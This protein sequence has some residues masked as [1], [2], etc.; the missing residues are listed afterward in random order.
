MIR[1]VFCFYDF[2]LIFAYLFADIVPMIVEFSYLRSTKIVTIGY[3]CYIF[4]KCLINIAFEWISVFIFDDY[5]FL[6]IWICVG[7]DSISCPPDSNS[8]YSYA[9]SCSL[10]CCNQWINSHI[11]STICDEYDRAL[12]CHAREC[13]VGDEECIPYGSP[14]ESRK[15]LSYR[16]RTDTRY[17]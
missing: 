2:F 3:R 10:T 5:S 7:E 4:E 14:R 12:L 1:L 17:Y 11:G 8:K 6:C 16:C 9:Q 13:R 15:L